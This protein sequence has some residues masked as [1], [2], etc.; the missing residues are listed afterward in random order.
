MMYYHVL[1]TFNSCFTHVL[2]TF[3]DVFVVMPVH[4]HVIICIS[5]GGVRSK[6]DLELV[7]RLGNDKVR[8]RNVQYYYVTL[9]LAFVSTH[10]RIYIPANN[11]VLDCS[12]LFDTLSYHILSTILHL[13]SYGTTIVKK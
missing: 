12:T 4:M 11:S 7:R 9:P 10:R 8:N 13:T 2:F 1:L 5:A 3:T 6:E